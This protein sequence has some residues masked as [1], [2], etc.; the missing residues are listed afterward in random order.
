MARLSSL[1]QLRLLYVERGGR[2]YGEGVTQIEHAVQSAAMAEGEGASPALVVAALL[3]DVGHL[4][5][6]DAAKPDID[7]HHESVGARALSGLFG[8]EVCKPIALHVAAKRYLC[9]K[10]PG[11]LEA[12]SPASQHSLALQGGM[13]TARQAQAF[14][15][16]VYWREAV[17]LRRYD[18]LGK[19]PTL[20]GRTWA[21][22]E[23]LVAR[24]RLIAP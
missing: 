23:P 20:S 7:A 6:D 10:Q 19:S 13:F 18:D 1:E 22:F 2:T 24:A 21:D 9:L 4:F 8:P 16:Q 14:E 15:R 17:A 11:Y 3:H 12:L 5:E